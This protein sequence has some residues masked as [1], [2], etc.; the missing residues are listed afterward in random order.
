MG[1]HC[2]VPYTIL[3]PL[4]ANSACTTPILIIQ[5]VGSS[6]YAHVRCGRLGPAC[7]SEPKVPLDM[8]SW[9]RFKSACTFLTEFC[10]GRIHNGRIL[11]SQSCN[12]ASCGYED[13]DKTADAQA[14]LSLR[15]T[16]KQNILADSGM[17]LSP[18]T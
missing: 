2:N 14:D 11:D 6:T 7:S 9:R 1:I 4:R 13:F 8:N 12:N 3:E 10:H 17:L 18:I 16:H 15:W 5:N